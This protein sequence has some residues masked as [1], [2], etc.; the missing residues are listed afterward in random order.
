[1]RS[2][3]VAAISGVV[4]A[5]LVSGV[6]LAAGI[7]ND[8]SSPAPATAASPR[9]ASGPTVADVYRTARQAIVRVDAH[10]PGTPILPG[11]PRRDDRVATGTGFVI[12]RSGLIVTNDHV[13]SGGPI[14]EV[15]F[16]PAD[17]RIRAKVLGTDPSNDLAL[18]RIDPAT[19]KGG[20]TALPLGESSKVQVG[21]EAIALGTPFGL[22]RTLTLGVVSATDRKIDSPNGA[23]IDN[24][25][26]T[27]AAINP[28][29]SGGP[30]LDAD[31]RVIGINSQADTAGTGIGFAVPVD[32]LERDLPDLRAGRKPQSAFLGVSVATE[33]PRVVSVV[34][35]GAAARAGIRRGDVIASI[36][37]R[38]VVAPSDVAS[39]VQ[40]H[41]PGDQVTVVV[42]RGGRGVT[43]KVT[44]GRR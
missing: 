44:L 7:G 24:V 15:R 3:G 11:P 6:I 43:M 31:G 14:V 8:S 10:A 41:R 9:A 12:D 18:L 25:V 37:G 40:R 13:A 30:L 27:D 34:P 2:A 42:R 4:S 20:L 1:M 5:A 21:D 23:Q 33:S 38:P 28:G 22:E 17:K 29:N 35:G 16:T 26:Q 19:V 39:I 32:T 36:D